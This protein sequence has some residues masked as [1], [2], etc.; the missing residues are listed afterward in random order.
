MP[1]KESKKV[2]MWDCEECGAENNQKTNPS[3][4]NCGHQLCGNCTVRVHKVRGNA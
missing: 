2:Y 1:K 3:C 4:W